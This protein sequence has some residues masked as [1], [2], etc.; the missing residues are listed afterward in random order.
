MA[1]ADADGLFVTDGCD[2]DIFQIFFWT[3]VGNG[4]TGFT[5]SCSFSIA[6]QW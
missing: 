2:A 1:R 4:S 5:T 6:W 3:F